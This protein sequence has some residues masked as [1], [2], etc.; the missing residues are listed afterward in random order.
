MIKLG[1]VFR[2]KEREYVYLIEYN[3]IIFAAR[4][5]DQD[6]SEQLNTIYE[7]KKL[8][9]ET[10]KGLENEP[11]F[12]FVMLNTEEFKG[13][14][15]HLAMDAEHDVGSLVYNIIHPLDKED[16]KVIINEIKNGPVSLN[17]RKAFEIYQGI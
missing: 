9:G 10:T 15:A 13:R 1:D 2:H 17:L 8:R 16:V 12:C 4:I 7:K 3:D 11:I 5:L 14:V 6:E